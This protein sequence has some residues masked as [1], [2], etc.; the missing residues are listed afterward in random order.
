MRKFLTVFIFTF[1]P[2]LA[3]A[4]CAPEDNKKDTT[5]TKIKMDEETWLT[6]DSA[7]YAKLGE[8]L[9]K[10]LFSPTKVKCYRL[11]FNDSITADDIQVERNIV[12]GPLVETLNRK[13][14]ALMQ[15]ALMKPAESYLMDSVAVRAPYDPVLEFVF[16]RRNEKAQVIV[17]PNNL[18]WTVIY[19][20]KRQFNYNFANKE[21]LIRFFNYFINKKD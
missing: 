6:P 10:I 15:F 11:L 9:A 14:I 8:K 21:T 3:F 20:N 16:S 19:D 17:S 12:R 4:S 18:T 5:E 13:Q 7:S 1:L 2:L